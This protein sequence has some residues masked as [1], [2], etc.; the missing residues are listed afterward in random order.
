MNQRKARDLYSHYH[1]GSLDEGLRQAFERAMQNDPDIRSEYEQFVRVIGDLNS[2]AKPVEV[3][4]DLHQRIRERLD[5]SVPESRTDNRTS[6]I[7]WAWKPL[8][9]GTAAAAIAIM[10]IVSFGPSPGGNVQ[11]AGLSGQTEIAPN[12]EVSDGNVMFEFRTGAE[13]SITVSRDS[14][15]VE[16][17]A[18]DLDGQLVQ[19]TLHNDA[20]EPSMLR[21]DIASLDRPVYL[22]IPGIA[23]A[24]DDAGSG[25]L[26][27]FATAISARYNVPVYVSVSDSEAILD[28]EFESL[29]PV[30]AVEDEIDSLGM[31]VAQDQNGVVRISD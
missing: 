25:S 2:M 30:E 13:T 4:A 5:Q 12:L 20:D 10:M 24:Q 8:A 19:L 7:W 15:N 26:L 3:P 31:H 6:T 27:E 11:S 28:W 22:L 1:E 14:D 21:V 17:F 18:K 9:Y 29:D 16:L 23:L